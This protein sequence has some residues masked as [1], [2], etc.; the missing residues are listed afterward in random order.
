MPSDY[1]ARLDAIRSRAPQ[2]PDLL[3][4]GDS[5]TEFSD[6]PDRIRQQLRADGAPPA[7]W[8]EALAVGGWSTHQGLIQLQRDI[9]PLAPSAVTFYFGWND[10][11]MGFGVADKEIE[12]SAFGNSW[13][14]QL[15]LSQLVRKARL[16]IRSQEQ[17]PLR[18]SEPDFRENLVQMARLSRAAGTAP[19]FV[20]A[21][22]SIERGREPEK[23]RERH[24]RD[25]LGVKRTT[26]HAQRRQRRVG[27]VRAQ[28]RNR[29][30]RL[31]R[32]VEPH[33]E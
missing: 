3:L 23:L 4:L 10:H 7:P 31:R 9:L 13:L 27:R 1:H 14:R 20:T 22:S 5:C 28:Q 33:L 11:W 24:L 16:A 2:R 19:I 30:R 29:Q 6:Y 15:R 32:V 8:I 17:S 18:V 25:R 26:R 21:A 12:S